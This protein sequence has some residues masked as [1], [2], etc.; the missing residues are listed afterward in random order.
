MSFTGLEDVEQLHVTFEGNFQSLAD[1]SPIGRA[2]QGMQ[3]LRHL[4]LDFARCYALTDL[5]ALG[6]GL[7]QLGDVELLILETLAI[8]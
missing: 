4:H 1:V 2:L 3:G 6:H 5:H 7:E 8:F